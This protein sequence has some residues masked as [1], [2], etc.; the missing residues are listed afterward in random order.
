MPIDYRLRQRA[1]PQ[2]HAEIR[3]WAHR[4]NLDYGNI[5][6]SHS[7]ERNTER[8]YLRSDR[9]YELFALSWCPCN[10]DFTNYR[11]GKE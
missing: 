9:A 1:I 8:V 2:L 3:V 10:P 11:I 6:V 5:T 7:A 4:H